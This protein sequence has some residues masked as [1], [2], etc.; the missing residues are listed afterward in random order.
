MAGAMFPA[1]LYVGMMM[2]IFRCRVL[3]CEATLVQ[4][5]GIQVEHFFRTL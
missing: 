1:S 3:E 4:I 2:L 5:T